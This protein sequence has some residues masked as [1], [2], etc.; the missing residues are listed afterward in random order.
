VKIS[1]GIRLTVCAFC[2]AG[3]V[4]GGAET[5]LDKPPQTISKVEP[6]YPYALRLNGNKGEVLLEFTV[7]ASGDVLNPKI[8]KSTHPEFEAPAVEALL[9]W[10]FTPGVKNGRAVNT[11]MQVPIWFQLAGRP[12]DGVDAFLIP[13][14]A[15]KTLPP[16]FQ[17]D[18]APRPTLT[19]APVY[20]F[21][22][23][24]QKVKGSA[25]VTF[26]IDPQGNP[27]K[28]TVLEATRPEFG[29]A[30]IAMMATWKFEPAK[31]DGKPTWAF[32][33]KKQT[34]NRTDRD[35]PV[36]NST[37]RLLRVLAK[38]PEDVLGDLKDLDAKPT[39]RFQPEPIVP[40][41]MLTEPA[42][43]QADIEF[44]ID[45]TG[46]AQLP[47]VVST[48]RADFGWAAA[49]AVARWRF[50]PPTKNGKPVDVRV[51]I[52]VVYESP[53]VAGK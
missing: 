8:I 45:R 42:N 22:L 37:E 39:A 12:G 46:R 1:T 53:A 48:S 43:A 28:I 36:D 5:K 24:Q 14:K 25:T 50:T 10:K 51:R 23:L 3:A 44:I 32:L 40:E 41:I 7:N 33:R 17:Y 13:E 49:T 26:N 16:E 29:A 52:P 20:P 47:R 31:K 15:P 30:T 9:K 19:A 2:I 21:E 34:F 11:R 4:A 27:R 18:Q 35:S 6:E 38:N